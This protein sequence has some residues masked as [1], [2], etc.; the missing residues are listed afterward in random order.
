MAVLPVLKMVV[1]V[2]LRTQ[3][4]EELQIRLSILGAI[5]P[6]PIVA[7][8]LEAK[9]ALTD[10]VLVQHSTDNFGHRKPGKDSLI[11]TLRQTRQLRSQAHATDP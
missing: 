5:I 7:R 8:E 2:F 11:E 1:N 3:S 9:G 10:T 6:R 4:L